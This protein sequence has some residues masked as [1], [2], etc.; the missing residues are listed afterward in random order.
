VGAVVA[1][2]QLCTGTL[3]SSKIVVTAAHC[4]VDYDPPTKFALGPTTD[5]AT[6]ILDIAQFIAHPQYGQ[7]VIG[8][9]LLNVHD[10]A[11]VVLAT[12]AKA[13]PMAY[14][15]A[16]IDGMAGLEVQFSGFGKTN[17]NDSMS[18]GTK[19]VFQTVIGS[20]NSQGLYNFTSGSNPKNTC[21]G[22]SGGPAILNQ[23]GKDEVISVVSAGDPG[24]VESGWNTRVDIHAA[25][26]Q[27][28]IQTHDPGGTTTDCGNGTCD[29]GESPT[30]CPQDCATGDCG[31]VTF[32]GCCVGQL[33]KWCE[34]GQLKQADCADKPSCGWNANG[35]FYDCGTDGAGDPSGNN[36]IICGAEPPDP[37]CGDG[38]CDAGETA[39]C[40]QD[41]GARNPDPVCGNGTCEIGED[42]STCPQDCAGRTP[43]PVCGNG[44]C[45][46][47]ESSTS[48]PGD[49]GGV[50]PASCGDG[51]CSDG[52]ESG[53]PED[54]G[55][56]PEEGCSGWCPEEEENAGG[57]C[58]PGASTGWPLMGILVLLS[59]YWRRGEE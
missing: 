44:T 55:E 30:S 40:P 2:R 56:D 19:M 41:C 49:C 20:V 39:T 36:P 13:T 54:C 7:E 26:L 24:C 8:N 33:L 27:Q 14:R 15:T 12:P 52:E 25:W 28:L 10:I 9:M 3:I 38:T 51:V 59:L 58:S 50:T 34:E 1:N 23:G 43:D 17:P 37:V 35:S 42:S 16:S 18:T 32:Q 22:D 6:E 29:S 45:E 5:K 11:I 4:Y 31:G 57:G 48:C 53:C 47:G 21:G 46:I